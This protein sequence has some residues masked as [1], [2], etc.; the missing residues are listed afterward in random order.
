MQQDASK[1]SGFASTVLAARN[2]VQA[3]TGKIIKTLLGQ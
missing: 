2:E 3:Q 1:R